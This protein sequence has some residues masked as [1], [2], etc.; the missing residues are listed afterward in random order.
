MRLASRRRGDAAVD[1][2]E[3]RTVERKRRRPAGERFAKFQSRHRDLLR[4]EGKEDAAATSARKVR[5]ALHAHPFRRNASRRRYCPVMSAVTLTLMRTLSL[6]ANIPSASDDNDL[7]CA[8]PERRPAGKAAD[9]NRQPVARCATLDHAGNDRRGPAVSRAPARR[10]RPAP[11]GS[12]GD[13]LAPHSRLQM[14]SARKPVRDRHRKPRPDR[15][16][17]A[18]GAP[19]RRSGAVRPASDSGARRRPQP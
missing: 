5:L 14:P 12:A 15:R 7:V 2:G 8:E 11:R 18:A 4:R 16:V 19:P 9:R 10:A 6:S 1:P 3:K 13:M 17:R